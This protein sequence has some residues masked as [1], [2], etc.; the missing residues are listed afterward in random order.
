MTGTRTS[1]AAVAQLPAISLAEVRA[2]ADLPRRFDHKHIVGPDR[3]ALLLT[4]L[5]DQLQVLE[6]EGER[7]STYTTTYF[8]TPDLRSYRDHR[9]GRRRRFKVRTRHYGDPAGTM[10]ELKRKARRGQ[11]DK[12]RWPHPGDE[13]RHLPAAARTLLG[14]VLASHDGM[15]LPPRLEPVAVTRFRRTTLVDTRAEERITIDAGLEVEVDGEV[16]VL[17]REALIVETKSARRRGRA[18]RALAAVGIQPLPVSKYGLSIS[19][20]RPELQGPAWRPALRR[21]AAHPPPP[22][23]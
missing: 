6:V 1:P 12:H 16:H 20:T 18:V 17:A 10:L 22:G 9:Q 4:R 23:A 7:T 3:L 8:D 19:V 14:E 21:L 2:A 5:G 13:P 15:R 11:T